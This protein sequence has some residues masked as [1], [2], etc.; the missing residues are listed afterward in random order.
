MSEIRKMKKRKEI[1]DW[2]VSLVVVI[3][4]ALIV[5]NFVLGTNL[6]KGISMEPT[7]EHNDYVILNKLNYRF[8]EPKRGDIV[9]CS[10]DK[11]TQEENIIKRVI[12]TPGDV[13]DIETGD[14][15]QYIVL[16]NGEAIDESYLGENMEQKGDTE[17]PYTVPQGCY[18]VMGDNRN[19]SNDSRSKLIGAIPKANIEGKVIIR[20]MPFDRFATF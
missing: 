10:Y 19:S 2:I 7:F 3:F 5:R 8:S 13:I 16:V 4:I 18:F 17:Y 9:V 1:M 20:L 14:E 6:V 11:G 12:G 15:Y